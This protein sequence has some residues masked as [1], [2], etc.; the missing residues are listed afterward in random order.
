[1]EH[2]LS[3]SI[4]GY[5]QGY[6]MLS[7]PD[8]KDMYLKTILSDVIKLEGKL[9]PNYAGQWAMHRQPGLQLS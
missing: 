3:T 9:V 4:V 5:G 6:E 1:M 8:G 7:Q 2:S